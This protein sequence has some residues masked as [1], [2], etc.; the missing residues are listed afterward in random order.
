[1]ENVRNCIAQVLRHHHA[2]VGHGTEEY[3]SIITF[4]FV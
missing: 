1:M 4:Y 3:V 2:Y